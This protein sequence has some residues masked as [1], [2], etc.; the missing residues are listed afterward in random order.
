MNVC[1]L[2][3]HASRNLLEYRF[4]LAG[5]HLEQTKVLL[6]GKSCQGGRRVGRS[7]DGLHEQLCNFLGG[8]FVD[9]AVDS[10]NATEGRDRIR[11]QR[12]LVRGKNVGTSSGAARI[13]MFDDRAHGL[14][15]LATK[16]PCCIEVDKIV[17]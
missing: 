4:G 2:K 17:V 12:P 15:K 5:N 6:G 7:R 13:R 16:L 8:S 11:L 10:D 9:L 1:I 3:Q 14:I